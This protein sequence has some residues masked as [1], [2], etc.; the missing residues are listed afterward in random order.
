MNIAKMMQQAKKM[1]DDMK[2]M[3]EKLKTIDVQASVSGVS[4]TMAGSGEVKVIS[5][6][7]ALIKPEDK[8]TLED[9]IVAALNQ[10]RE[11]M[12]KMVG[13]ETKKIMGGM[14]LPPGMSLPF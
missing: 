3:Q 9:L 10:A 14:Q 4:V 13:E 7:A 1:Q 11:K 8:E 6:D 12:D 5:I 2:S